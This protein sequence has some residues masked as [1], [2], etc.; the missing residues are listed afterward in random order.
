MIEYNSIMQRDPEGKSGGVLTPQLESTIPAQWTPSEARLDDLDDAAIETRDLS[1]RYQ[2]SYQIGVGGMGEVRACRDL[3]IGRDV[4]LKSFR[5]DKKLGPVTPETRLRLL[6]EARV[7]GQLEHPAI[8]PVHELARDDEGREYFTMR[9]ISGRT[10]ADVIAGLRKEEEETTRSFSRHKL[11][12]AF[13]QICLAIDYAHTRGVIHRDIKP[14]NIM[15]GEY[16]EVYVL[17]WGLAK[18][19]TEGDDSI[20]DSSVI[21]QTG[22]GQVMGTPGYMSPE[23]SAG[24]ADIDAQSDVYSLGAILFEM[25][26]L[27]PLHEGSGRAELLKSTKIGANA[28]ISER[29]PDQDVAPELEALCVEATALLL[30]ER[31][32]RARDL[33]DA[34]ARFLEGDRDL[35]RRRE[36]AGGHATTAREAADR[37]FAGGPEANEDRALAL[38]ELGRA[39]ALTPDDPDLALMLGKLL[40]E[41]P[42]EPPPEALAAVEVAQTE[43]MRATNIFGAISM[44]GITS[45]L[46]VALWLGIRQWHWVIGIVLSMTVAI[47]FALS[48]VQ[49]QKHTALASFIAMSFATLAI[50]FTSGLTGPLLLSPM[51]AVVAVVIAN[52]SPTL[53]ASFRGPVLIL[54]ILSFVV[55][56]LLE[57]Q[58]V[59]PSTYE[60]KG[61]HIIIWS[62]TI[63]FPAE[64]RF[65]LLFTDIVL[66]VVPA[67]FVWRLGNSNAAYRRELLVGRWQL[68]QLLP[69]DARTSLV[70]PE[71]GL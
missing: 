32:A 29:A 36:L 3:A 14:A 12:A 28:R 62:N 51:I 67:L 13:L 54:A 18:L 10:L 22:V 44:I 31:T 52:A 20:V 53:L 2:L 11:L 46:F 65:G 57:W 43:E 60:F 42:S 55:P 25:L 1:K 61:D 58:G 47:G 35:L 48:I 30:N 15:L 38:S 70:S 64:T 49:T 24:Q 5:T 16:G 6:R 27:L 19:I 4:A 8:V 59:M 23:Q 50:A 34:V 63:H 17:D 68:Q 66:L 71:D 37:A 33:H 39:L 26:A 45:L 9:R 69:K 21:H 56:A 40:T 7:Q 41:P